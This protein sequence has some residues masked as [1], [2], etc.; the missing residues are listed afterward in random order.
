M[1]SLFLKKLAEIGY[2]QDTLIKHSQQLQTSIDK[3][4][5]ESLFI[6]YL[7]FIGVIIGGLITYFGQYFLKNKD[8]KMALVKETRDTVSKMFIG[9]TSLNFSLRELA[10]L[11][12]DS[13][14]Q[15]QLSCKETGDNQKRALEEHYNDYKYIAECRGKIAFGQI[16]RNYFADI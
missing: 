7:P 3:I 1:D 8:L 12:V 2:L 6:K 5:S 9:L 4:N 11:E 13:K 10:Y 16:F 15:Y 14:Y